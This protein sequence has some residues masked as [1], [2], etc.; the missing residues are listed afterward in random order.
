MFH[1]ILQK[2]FK[3]LHKKQIMYFFYYLEQIE[4]ENNSD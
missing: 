1:M 4:Y 2:L 3:F